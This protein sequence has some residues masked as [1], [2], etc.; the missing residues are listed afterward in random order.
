VSDVKEVVV[1][2][3]S[4]LTFIAEVLRLD[5]AQDI[6]LVKIPGSGH[7][8]LSLAIGQPA[9][10]GSDVFAIGAPAG[11]ELAFSVSKGVVSAYREK[12]GSQYIQTDASL[13]PGNSGGPLI[14]RGGLIEGIVSWKIG[15]TGYEGLAFGVP[16]SVVAQRLGINWE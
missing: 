11:E 5:T 9:A 8:C 2:F 15:L 12:D 6:A 14:G 10:I 13:N 4:G 16:P 3:R 1:K 7:H